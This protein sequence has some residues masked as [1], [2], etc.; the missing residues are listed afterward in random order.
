MIGC[1][2]YDM[3]TAFMVIDNEVMNSNV[4]SWIRN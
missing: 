3:V 4:A 1:L 2:G